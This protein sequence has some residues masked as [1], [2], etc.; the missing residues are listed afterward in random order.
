MTALYRRLNK[1]VDFRFKFLLGS[2]SAVGTQPQF[3]LPANM[4][5]DYYAVANGS[6]IGGG[7]LLDSGTA[8]RPAFLLVQSA[9]TL[10]ISYL[11][12]TPAFADITASLPQVWTTSDSLFVWGTYETA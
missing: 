9:T 7:V 12:A 11:N 1:T 8:T 4:A 6:A 5:A 10:M 2:T 3:T